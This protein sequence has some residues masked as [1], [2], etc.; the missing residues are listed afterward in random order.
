[1]KI[2]KFL[3]NVG[4]VKISKEGEVKVKD[5]EHIT[6]KYRGYA[7]QDCNLNFSLSK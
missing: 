7:H 5:H 6:G 3:P 2:S 1:M 4:F